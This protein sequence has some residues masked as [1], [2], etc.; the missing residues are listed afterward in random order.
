MDQLQSEFAE[1]TAE[2]EFWIDFAGW[3]QPR[4]ALSS[5]PRIFEAI[6][7]AVDRY[8]KAAEALGEPDN[9][10]PSTRGRVNCVG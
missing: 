5:E 10:A 4:H 1:A 9:A 6:S 2:L 8:N 7:N 3:W